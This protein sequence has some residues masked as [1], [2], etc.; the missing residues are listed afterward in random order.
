[1]RFYKDTKFIL[2]TMQS[3]DATFVITMCIYSK[4]K[5]LISYKYKSASL[6]L[7]FWRSY[8]NYNILISC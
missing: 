7:I 4:K 1:M 5:S 8:G 3:T 6:G 2:S